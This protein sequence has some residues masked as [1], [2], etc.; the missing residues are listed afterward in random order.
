MDE[1][2]G[3]FPPTANPP[4]KTP[5]LT[6]LK[7]ARAYG[8]GVVLATQNP[9]DLDYKGLGNAGT[10][11]LGRLQTERDK[12]RVLDGLESAASGAT[13]PRA[14]LDTLLS[15]L[16]QR[17]FLMVNAHDDAPTLFQT[18]WVLSYLRGP[19]TR[20]Q[21]AQL[22]G[23]A[24]PPS[25]SPGVAAGAPP[26][27]T[28]AASAAHPVGVGARA[29]LPPGVTEVF[30]PW[31]G[32]AAGGRPVYRPG[33]LATARL[34]Y[35]D[36]K[37]AVDTWESVALSAPVPDELSTEPWAAAE[38]LVGTPEVERQAAPDAAFAAVPASATR[39][40]SYEIWARAAEDH[41]YRTRTL[42]LW[43]CA[44]PKLAGQP[45]ESEGDFRARLTQ[46]ARES[47]DEAVEGLRRT[48]A[49][50][51]QTLEDRIR[52]AEERVARE[53]S[54]ASQAQVSSGISIAGAVL[55]ALF[56][57]RKVS[58]GTISRAGTAARG[59]GR[60]GK[61]AKDVARAEEG[62]D[63]LRQ[64]MAELEATIAAEAAQLQA[65]ND[66]AALELEEGRIAPRKSDISVAGVVLAWTPHPSSE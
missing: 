59:M 61:E 8:L 41:L 29:V 17:T 45:G 30:R 26:A 53:K 54:Q 39:A 19:L 49:A 37:S 3:Y 60:A 65:D 42:S 2:F 24:A 23:A 40:K 36:A 32:G 20:E 34:H 48:Y 43:R 7:Q 4:A 55:G 31:R 64:R 11:F 46:A 51:V 57:R 66:P 28:R 56:G 16:K 35:V 58:V 9:V 14:K 33:L 5:M 13:P 10:W 47:R 38:V 1:V 18:R 63:V 44:R 25:A 6:L 52:T 21:I 27:A 62:V 50:K 12:L 22:K 15:N